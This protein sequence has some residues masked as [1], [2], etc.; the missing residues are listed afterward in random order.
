MTAVKAST[1]IGTGKTLSAKLKGWWP[2]FDTPTPSQITDI[3]GNGAH[4]TAVQ[5][6]LTSIDTIL[7][8][9]LQWSNGV[10]A[11][12]GVAATNT[13]EEL[14][15]ANRNVLIAFRAQWSKGDGGAGCIMAHTDAG[16]D[17]GVLVRIAGANEVIS[18]GVGNGSTYVVQQSGTLVNN[19]DYHIAC[20][21]DRASS[22]WKVYIDGVDNT[23]TSSTLPG[24]TTV[25]TAGRWCL[26]GSGNGTGDL[27]DLISGK[28]SAGETF[29]L[30]DVQ[31]YTEDNAAGL[32]SDIDDLIAYL[33][34]HEYQAL[35]E[36]Q[37]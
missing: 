7:P 5:S 33:A 37:W 9:R 23:A 2:G 27:G 1:S 17:N 14:S 16:E 18:L 35:S 15:V 6:A 21:I 11:M 10:S 26:G 12:A 22:A 31:I 29:D 13:I 32:P 20:T 25:G 3:S 8:G 4:L 28:A 36:D 34:A 24:P 19:T 30:W